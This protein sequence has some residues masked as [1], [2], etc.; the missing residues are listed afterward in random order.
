MLFAAFGVSSLAWDRRA[1]PRHVASGTWRFQSHPSTARTVCRW[2]QGVTAVATTWP[3]VPGRLRCVLIN[4]WRAA[5][6]KK[7]LM[8]WRRRDGGEVTGNALTQKE[9]LTEAPPA[10]WLPLKWREKSY[11]ALWRRKVRP[12]Q[13]NIERRQLPAWNYWPTKSTKPVPPV[14][15]TVKLTFNYAHKRNNNTPCA[16]KKCFF[17]FIIIVWLTKQLNCYHVHHSDW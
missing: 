13:L 5:E 9:E 14:A 1:A 16:L 11:A 6:K 2:S 4:V 15:N 7:R 10:A 3:R 8:R 12:V 17:C